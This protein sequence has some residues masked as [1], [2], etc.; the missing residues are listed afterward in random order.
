M[1]SA[2]DVQDILGLPSRDSG[3]PQP[4]KLKRQRTV[5]RTKGLAGVQRELASLIGERTPPIAA[6]EAEKL[7]KPKRHRDYRRVY[8]WY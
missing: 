7:Y 8:K 5:P 1:A 4:A 3:V 2:K 6:Q